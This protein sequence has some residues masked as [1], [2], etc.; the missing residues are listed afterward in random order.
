MTDAMLAFVVAAAIAQVQVAEPAEAPPRPA[1]ARAPALTIGSPA[2][3]PDVA[4]FVRG[5]RPAFFEPGKTYVLEFWA[6]WCG[7]C[8][9]SMPHLS[10]LAE[11]FREKGVVVVG[12]SDEKPETVRDFLEKDEWRQRARYVLATDPDRST[13]RMY[14]EASGQRGIPTAFLVRDGVV[15]WIGHP[16]ELEGPL[17]KAAAGTW[18]WKAAKRTFEDAMA[19]EQRAMGRQLQMAKAID[20][21]EWDRA[22]AML[23]EDLAGAQG[24]DAVQLRVQKALVLMAAGRGD[25]GYALAEELVRAEPELRSWL[26]AGVLHMPDLPDRRVD[27]AIG[28][29]EQAASEPGAPPQV[30]AELGFAWGAKGDRSK[31]AG[32]VRLAIAAARA[33]GPGAAEYVADLDAQLKELEASPRA[34]AAP[35]GAAAPR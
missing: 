34:P 18:D 10:D 19:E 32:Y 29:L 30:M 31:A 11:R 27:V 1:A 6:T 21:K 8:R 33:L 23:D 17:A 13:Q 16:M 15:Q 2:P 7:P 4:E 28:W 12:I 24:D 26:A 20:G 5:E 9:Q 25:A 3:V 22:L 14:M 35:A